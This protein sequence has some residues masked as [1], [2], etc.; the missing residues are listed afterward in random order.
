[1][2]NKKQK[3]SQ[4]NK[5]KLKKQKAKIKNKVTCIKRKKRKSGMNYCHKTEEFRFPLVE[6]W[7][8]D[9][10]NDRLV[11]ILVHFF[12]HHSRIHSAIV[13]FMI[14]VISIGFPCT[15]LIG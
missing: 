2:K 4:K 12:L 3:A 7:R 6:I 13:L 15:L 10:F 8:R 5:V 1:M 11:I 9:E 14:F